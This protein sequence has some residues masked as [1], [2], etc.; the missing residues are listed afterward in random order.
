MAWVK[1]PLN[2]TDWARA[3]DSFVESWKYKGKLLQ[4]IH[5]NDRV[6]VGMFVK[7]EPVRNPATITIKD[8]NGFIHEISLS[9]VKEIA[10]QG[11]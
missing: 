7:Y 6:S 11:S 1:I 4:I 8:D 9:D 10:Y 5:A 3:L 2:A